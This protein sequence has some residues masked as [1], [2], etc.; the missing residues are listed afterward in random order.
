[1]SA[2]LQPAVPDRTPLLRVGD[3]AK[4]TGKTVRAIHLYEELGLLKPATRSSGGFRLFDS[5]AVDRVRWIDSLHGLGF[6]LQ[7]MREVLQNWWTAEQGPKA[8]AELRALFL[9]KLDQTRDALRRHQNLVA[10]L[11]EGLRYLE[12]CENCDAPGTVHVCVNC[13][14]DHGGGAPSLVA[15]IHGATEVPPKASRPA[16][17]RVEDMMMQSPGPSAAATGGPGDA[18]RKE[19]QQ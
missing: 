7:E 2:N 15:G 8:M 11:E 12:T 1:M 4:A 16:F 17:V 5:S 18:S 9:R 13:Q 10:E 6:S 19:Q 3:I 14:Q